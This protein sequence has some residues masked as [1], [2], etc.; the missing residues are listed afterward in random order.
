MEIQENISRLPLRN[1]RNYE[2]SV[3]T[4]QDDFITVLKHSLLE[5]KGQI[6]N[7]EMTLNVDGTQELSFS[8]PLYYSIDGV[9]VENPLWNLYKG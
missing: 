7:G 1:I 2:I 8:I 5:N 6:Q 9:L 4:L 3:W